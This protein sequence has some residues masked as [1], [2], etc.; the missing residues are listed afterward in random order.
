MSVPTIC[1]TTKIVHRSFFSLL[2]TSLHW[3]YLLVVYTQ[4]VTHKRLN[5]NFLSY[6]FNFTITIFATAEILVV[7]VVVLWHASGTFECMSKSYTV[8][9]IVGDLL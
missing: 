7:L 1:F 4:C 5:I 8:K 3:K 2:H 9:Q 6:A